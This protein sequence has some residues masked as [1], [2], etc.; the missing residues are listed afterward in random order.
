[1]RKPFDCP[2]ANHLPSTSRPHGYNL[3]GKG[4]ETGGEKWGKNVKRNH[5]AFFRARLSYLI[6][7]M[8]QGLIMDVWLC[9]LP[10]DPTRYRSI[11]SGIKPIYSRRIM[12]SLSPGAR[13][14]GSKPSVRLRRENLARSP[15][16]KDRIQQLKAT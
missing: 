11:L 6:A 1:M 9:N 14:L 2:L 7:L 13:R 5:D 3:S 12:R 4:V 10:K 16:S 15:L 8:R